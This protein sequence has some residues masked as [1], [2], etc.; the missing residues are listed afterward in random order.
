MITVKENEVYKRESATRFT[1]VET[2]TFKQPTER[3]YEKADYD[4]YM[5]VALEKSD[6]VTE[7][8]HLLTGELLIK[9]RNAIR[10]GYQH[11]LDPALQ[12]ALR[13]PPKP[14]HCKGNRGIYR[15]DL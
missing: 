1:L 3:V 6:K 15:T 12:K 2:I 7:D 11:Q 8:R 14:E 9:Y 5:Q 4:W 10:E 13:L